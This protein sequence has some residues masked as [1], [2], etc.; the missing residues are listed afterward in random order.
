MITFSSSSTFSIF[1]ARDDFHFIYFPLMVRL[2]LFFMIF[3][4]VFPIV[5]SIASF[6]M[7]GCSLCFVLV[8]FLQFGLRLMA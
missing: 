2:L 4:E 8:G 6:S 1:T 5:F 3:G 7:M